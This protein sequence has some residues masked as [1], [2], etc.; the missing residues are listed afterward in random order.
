MS[1]TEEPWE[2]EQ[3]AKQKILASTISVNKA[4]Y[5]N[6]ARSSIFD[7]L[8]RV[9]VS[10]IKENTRFL[11]EALANYIF[12][13]EGNNITIFQNS[14]TVDELV[15]I[16]LLSPP[17]L[18]QLFSSSPLFLYLSPSPSPSSFPPFFST[19]PFAFPSLYFPCYLP[20]SSFYS[21][22][23]LFSALF[24]SINT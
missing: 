8:S 11:A 1:H 7:N 20:F 24:C 15:F 12:K 9:N 19:L 21:S 5:P 17:F 6:L 10:L 14:L 4:P 13:L 22:F 3:F 23:L 16:L 2:H 18:F